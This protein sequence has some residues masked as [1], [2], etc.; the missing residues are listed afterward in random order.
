MIAT[1]YDKYALVYTCGTLFGVRRFESMWVLT[2]KAYEV[3]S[4][5]FTTFR[6]GTITPIISKLFQT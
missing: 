4:K 1:D 3:G 6:D 5:E 2:R